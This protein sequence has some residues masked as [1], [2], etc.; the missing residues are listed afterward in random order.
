MQILNDYLV[1]GLQNR[2]LA[3][4]SAIRSV[5]APS[6][7]PA[8]QEQGA[9]AEISVDSQILS[10]MSAGQNNRLLGQ[11]SIRFARVLLAETVNGPPESPHGL[12]YRTTIYNRL[13]RKR[14]EDP[15]AADFKPNTL[16]TEKATGDRW[17]EILQHFGLG[18]LALL[19]PYMDGQILQKMNKVALAKFIFVLEKDKKFSSFRSISEELNMWVETLRF[20]RLHQARLNEEVHRKSR[21][22]WGANVVLDTIAIAQVLRVDAEGPVFLP[23]DGTLNLEPTRSELLGILHNDHVASAIMQTIIQHWFSSDFEATLIADVDA[24]ISEWA[25][26]QYANSSIQDIYP[27]LRFNTHWVFVC[28]TKADGTFLM[29]DPSKDDPQAVRRYRTVFRKLKLDVEIGRHE[30]R[31]APGFMPT[32]FKRGRRVQQSGDTDSGILVLLYFD[33]KRQRSDIPQDDENLLEVTAMRRRY[34]R[35][36][37]GRRAISIGLLK[38][39]PAANEPGRALPSSN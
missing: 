23:G 36:L 38:P 20:S 19:P 28:I 35:Q 13:T 6:C 16:R 32:V 30:N 2:Q 7:V 21:A 33:Y 9:E 15:N 26:T 18:G 39:L 31:F 10:L 4:I 5:I 27:A 24:S 14:R 37:T 17:I 1:D 12:G 25:A 29:L 22:Q 34:V 8:I 11:L 3:L